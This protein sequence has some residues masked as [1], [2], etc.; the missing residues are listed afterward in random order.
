ML[1]ERKLSKTALLI[2]AVASTILFSV[3]RIGIGF[4]LGHTDAVTAF[5]AA[6]S[7]AVVLI[8]VYYSALAFFV[9]ALVA[10]YV[11]EEQIRRIGARRSSELRSCVVRAAFDRRSSIPHPAQYSTATGSSDRHRYHV[12][13]LRHGRQR[14]PCRRIVVSVTRRPR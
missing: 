14:V 11:E 13:T 7:L 10:R 5:G 1:P 12:A 8:W 9:G 3:G 4:Y 2:G 6:G